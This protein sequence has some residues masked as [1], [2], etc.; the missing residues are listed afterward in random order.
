M[1]N[2][3]ELSDIVLEKGDSKTLKL[4][5]ILILVAFLILVFLVALASMKMMNKEP[6]KE[7][8]KLI[9]PPEPS[10]Q[11]APVTK[12]DQ[13]FKQVPIIEENPKKES[14]E[15]M[16]KTLKEKEAQK[17][18][19]AKVKE[20]ATQTTA[21]IKSETPKV[22]ET[23]PKEES[24]KKEVAKPKEAPAPVSQQSTSADAG[25][26]IQIGAVATA[27]EQKVLN[28]I[29]SKGFEYRL[30]KTVVNGN[31]V[32]KILIGPYAKSEDAQNALVSVRASLN[33]NAFIYRIK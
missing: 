2:R 11:E 4:K 6:S 21:P 31:N 14:F 24:V 27:P 22:T 3:N 25:I 16:I 9:L 8:S 18:E 30:Y 17:Q 32:T 13:L 26:Y 23:K 7:T 28:D 10:A 29:K 15:E 1:E 33:K 20:S 19:E 12:D 5:R